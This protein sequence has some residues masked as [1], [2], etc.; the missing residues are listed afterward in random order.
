M[1]V[2]FLKTISQTTKCVVVLITTRQPTVD[3]WLWAL[4]RNNSGAQK[5]GRQN[6]ITENRNLFI[7]RTSR[8]RKNCSQ[9][10]TLAV[11]P[12][13]RT[14]FTSQIWILQQA[15]RQC[16][17][18]VVAQFSLGGGAGGVI[19]F[20]SRLDLEV[21]LERLQGRAAVLDV[22][23]ELD[24]RCIALREGH[25][26]RPEFAEGVRVPRSER[27]KVRKARLGFTC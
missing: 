10:T 27:G 23:A 8:C 4:L 2:E 5:L 19:Y 9:N 24:E 13:S 15:C 14:L 16:E 25:D 17:E 11:C 18:A 6:A 1:I 3:R 22:E 12:Q 21:D 20:V 26:G 7:K